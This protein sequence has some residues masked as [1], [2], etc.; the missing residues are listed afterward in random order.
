MWQSVPERRF[1]EWCED[2]NISIKNGPKVTYNFRE[3]QHVYRVDFELTHN[4]LLIEIKDN[5][6]W[7]KEQV[8]SGKFQAKESAAKEWCKINNY[9]Y[10]VIFPKT[11]QKLKDSILNNKP[12]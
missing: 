5:H 2:N 3:K 1:I 12:L 6:C 4:K 7:H 10:H 8:E 11:L 9:K